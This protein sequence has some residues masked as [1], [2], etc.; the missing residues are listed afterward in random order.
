MRGNYCKSILDENCVP[1][2]ELNCDNIS[3]YCTGDV[4]PHKGLIIRWLKTVG[5]EYGIIGFENTFDPISGKSLGNFEY[6]EQNGYGWSNVEVYLFETYNIKLK[7]TFLQMFEEVSE[8]IA[9]IK[10]EIRRSSGKA[11]DD[12]AK[13]IISGRSGYVGIEEEYSDTLSITD[14]SIE[15]ECSPYQ[16]SYMNP[17]QKWSYTT[18][19]P[20]FRKLFEDALKATR[21]IFE[22]DPEC[23]GTDMPETIFTVTYHNGETI[24]KVYL[25]SH[26]EFSYCYS[27]LKK[28]VPPCE[29]MP[30]VLKTSEDYWEERLWHS[31]VVK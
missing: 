14:D 5:V 13:I 22:R 20:A 17:V 29:L 4:V 26:N 12:P 9:E 21:E 18:N 15:Y 31:I 6:K 1:V 16:P 3:L 27:V 10:G 24:K 23:P 30:W 11:A 28:M 2:K 25:V 8:R 19:S 7:D